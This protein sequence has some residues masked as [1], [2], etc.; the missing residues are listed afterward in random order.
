[1]K[2][3]DRQNFSLERLSPARVKETI[4]QI[5]EEGQKVRWGMPCVGDCIENT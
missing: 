5:H 2:M 3:K 4:V 1:M